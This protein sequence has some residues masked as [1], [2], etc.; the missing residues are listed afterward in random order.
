MRSSVDERLADVAVRPATAHDLDAIARIYARYV[1]TST[2][3]F[4]VEPPTTA[5]W[6]ARLEAITARG[7]PF[8]VAEVGGGVAGYAYCG[9]WRTR[10]AYRFTVENSV[11]V[12]AELTGRG[13]G[14]ALMDELLRACRQAGIREV[15][16]VVTDGHA[17]SLALHRRSG[18]VEVGRLTRVGHKHGRW[19]DTLL[20]QRSLGP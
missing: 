11:Y 18:F 6:R 15:I 12:D 20:L 7:L 13:I 3:T 4:E 2:A 10:P 1:T 14:R 9:P 5:E 16:A 17:G 19:L 8:L